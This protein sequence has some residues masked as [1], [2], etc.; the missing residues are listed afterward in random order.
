M[1]F[2][3]KGKEYTSI[4]EIINSFPSD[5]D[6]PH[7]KYLLDYGPEFFF[8]LSSH[9]YVDLDYL[10]QNQMIV[11][12]EGTVIKGKLDKNRSKYLKVNNLFKLPSK[13][14][15]STNNLKYT[16]GVELETSRGHVPIA[17]Y[18]Q[19]NLNLKCE[20]DGSLK[21]PDG[22]DM[23]GEYITGVL[24]GDTGL[25]NLTAICEVLNSRCLIDKRAGMH[26]HVGGFKNSKYFAVAAYMLANKIQKEL[27]TVVAP[28]RRNNNTCG[29][30]PNE[31]NFIL[32]SIEKFGLKYGIDHVYHEIAKKMANGRELNKKVN[33]INQHPGGRY[34]DRYGG[35]GIGNITD[36]NKLYRYKVINLIPV[37]FNSKQEDN[38]DVNSIPYTIEFRNHQGTLNY[39]KVKNWLFL[40]MAFVYFCEN[41]QNKI[42]T[43]DKISINDIIY[44]TYGNRRAMSEKLISY[45]EERKS[46]FSISDTEEKEY[47][48]STNKA[49]TI[50]EVVT[51]VIN[52]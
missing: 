16:F 12:H 48:E 31:E 36:T 4:N 42:F 50:K 52:N 1:M 14:F 10:Q 35:H 26:I 24:T 23:G 18:L 49:K 33:K 39:E 34:T 25:Q 37:F 45:F 22:T 46:K 40:C 47:Q 11:A 43:S 17:Y 8:R 6:D 9:I 2:S 13:T 51:D 30:L 41:H 28:S 19:K 32:Q 44:A 3:Y 20:Y 38:K 21:D 15:V 29:Y 5:S 7:L 27:F